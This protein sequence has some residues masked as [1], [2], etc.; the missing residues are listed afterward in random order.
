[1]ISYPIVFST[2]LSSRNLPEWASEWH[3]VPAGTQKVGSSVWLDVG[4]LTLRFND[5]ELPATELSL[6][7]DIPQW[8]STS[9]LKSF[10]LLF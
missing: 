9:W 5:L 2:L 3:D 7:K 4:L 6:L 8:T 10:L 1:M